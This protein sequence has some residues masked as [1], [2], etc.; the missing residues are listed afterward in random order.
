MPG[1]YAVEHDGRWL[2]RTVRRRSR[3][4]PAPARRGVRAAPVP[5]GPRVGRQRDQPRRAD[6]GGGDQPGEPAGQR[7]RAGRAD[8][9][10]DGDGLPRGRGAGARGAPGPSVGPQPLLEPRPH[11]RPL[12]VDDRVVRAVARRAAGQDHVLAEDALE[13]GAQRD[14]G[15]ARALVARVGL[16]LHAAGAERLEGVAQQQQLGLRVDPRPPHGRRVPRVSDLEAQVRALECEEPRRAGDRPVRAHRE[17]RLLSHPRRVGRLAEPRAEGGGRRRRVGRQP[18]P[19]ARVLGGRPQLPRMLVAQRLEDDPPAGQHDGCPRPADHDGA[20]PASASA[21]RASR[22]AAMTSLNDRKRKIT[23]TAAKPSASVK[24]AMAICWPTEKAA[25]VAPLAVPAKTLTRKACCTPAPP[26]VKGTT[27]A[28]ALTPRTSST[29]RTEPPMLKAS[30]RFQKAAK[31]KSQPA[32]CTSQTS[33]R[34]R[35]RSRRMTSPWRTRAQNAAT[36]RENSAKATSA[37]TASAVRTKSRKRG[38]E[39]KNDRSNA[40]SEAKSG[41]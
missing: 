3:R 6:D 5:A 12:V 34:Y 28:T 16:E 15:A 39:A 2:R 1:G 41:G 24:T 40:P 38:C 37:P 23:T 27:E 31:R 4:V 14:Q 35:R 19:D 7:R 26:G 33:R 8:P 11:R 21:A 30:S 29:L 13:L 20:A 9:R 10:G 36:R 18:L 22:P 17:G 32:N 25:T